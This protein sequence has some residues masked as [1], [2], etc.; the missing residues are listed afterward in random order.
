MHEPCHFLWNGNYV[1]GV[2]R[3]FFTEEEENLVWQDGHL[4]QNYSVPSA[5][6]GHCLVNDPELRQVFPHLVFNS[7]DFLK[8][9][10]EACISATA[11]MNRSAHEQ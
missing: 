1:I 5:A 2:L 8:S 7:T 11:A 6:I 9:V 10:N 3:L 4:F